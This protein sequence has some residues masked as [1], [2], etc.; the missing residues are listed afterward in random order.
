MAGLKKIT[1]SSPGDIMGLLEEGNKR[2]KT[3]STDANSQS[4]RSHAVSST[5]R[6]G[7]RRGTWAENAGRMGLMV[8]VEGSVNGRRESDG[9]S[10]R[11]RRG[12]SGA[13]AP[14]PSVQVLEINVRRTPR[15]HYRV[16][17]LCAKLALV[18]LAGSE[19]AAGALWARMEESRS[20]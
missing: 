20:P 4:S 16:Q 19:R 10:Q 5:T 7:V 13:T 12:R 11:L 9:S 1:V 6:Q 2:R 15:N 3:E 8:S 17:Q 18:D 14:T